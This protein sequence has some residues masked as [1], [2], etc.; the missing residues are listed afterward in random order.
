MLEEFLEVFASAQPE[1]CLRR[2]TKTGHQK[3]DVRS[4]ELTGNSSDQARRLRTIRCVKKLL[5][6]MAKFLT[7]L[8]GRDGTLWELS[9]K[10]LCVRVFFF[11]F[12]KG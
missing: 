8:Y 10:T 3:E 7:G 9:V 11:F 4:I 1:A 6:G 2:F 5:L 12:W